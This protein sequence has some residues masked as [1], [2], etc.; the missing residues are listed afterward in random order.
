[1]D[2]EQKRGT[3]VPDLIF[4]WIII[5]GV[6]AGRAAHGDNGVEDYARKIERK[7]AALDSIKSEL[8]RGRRKLEELKR[9]EGSYLEQLAQVE[10]NIGNSQ[11]YLA[12]VR[13]TIDTVSGR[14]DTLLDSLGFAERKLDRRRRVMKERLRD[15]YKAGRAYK[16]DAPGLIRIAVTSVNIADLI[17]RVRYSQALSA[18]DKDLLEAIQETQLRILEHT[19]TLQAQREELLAL[20]AAKEEE[21]SMLVA[22]QQA[23]Q[24]T[25]EEV[26]AE[27][28]AYVAM[29]GELEQAQ[30]ELNLIIKQ[31]EKKRKEAEKDKARRAEIAFAK[32]K[33]ALPWPVDGKVVRRFGKIVHPV[34]KTVTMNHGIDIEATK[35]RKVMCVA[36]G[37]VDYVGW[38]RG[39]GK[40]VIVNHFDGYLTIYAHLGDIS[41]AQDQDVEY[42]TVLGVVGETG[43][44]SGPKL[45]FQIRQAT[46][47]ID[48]AGWLE[49]EVRS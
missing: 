4:V 44:L 40:F 39:Y 18:Y 37:R 38:M 6:A 13:R 47:P 17:H 22:E 2:G 35:G 20:R 14:I 45:H 42:G 31:L 34:Y 21:Q 5:L 30:S 25:L 19:E 16:T 29:V 36:P 23:R 11:S 10:K 33:G 1:M 49:K 15:I 7:S 3:Q 26:R 27:K 48:P 24:E 46:E 43:S 32:R 8:N 41:V 28:E 9:K 12:Q